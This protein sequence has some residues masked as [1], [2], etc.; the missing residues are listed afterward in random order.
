MPRRT[1]TLRAQRVPS[2]ELTRVV[3]TAHYFISRRSA[4]LLPILRQSSKH[5]AEYSNQHTYGTDG[6][7]HSC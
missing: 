5:V 7:A 6:M 1:D 2:K 4:A 3:Q